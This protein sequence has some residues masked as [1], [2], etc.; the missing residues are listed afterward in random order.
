MTKISKQFIAAIIT[1]AILLAGCA[2]TTPTL[3]PSAP[4]ATSAVPDSPTPIAKT[5]SSSSVETTRPPASVSPTDASDG[6]QDLTITILYDN[7]AYDARLRAD[8]GFA[9]LIEY[10]GHTL[11]FD[12]GGDGPTL[13]DNMAQLGIAPRSIEAIVLSHIHGDHTNGLQSVLDTDITPTVYVPAS[14][15]ASF[16]DNVRSQTDL[17]EIT[18]PVEIFP[19]LHSTGELGASIVEQALVV[20]TE[21]GIVVVTGCAHPGIV[22]IV[23]QA[24]AIVENRVALVVGGFHLLDYSSD[25]VTHIV[26][27]LRELGVRQVCPTHCTGDA[28][29]AIFAAQY[30]DDY[31]QGGVGRVITVAGSDEAHVSGLADDEIATLTSL[32]RVDDYPLYTMHYYGDYSHR[33][34]A[35]GGGR[36]RLTFSTPDW[37]CSLFAAL[38]D[39]DNMLY[40]RNFDWEYSPALLLFT[41]PTDGYASVS[42]VDI[43][44]LVGADV[45]GRLTD[46]PFEER[47]ALLDAP[48]WP[49]DGMNEHGLVIGMAAV[50]PG[51]VSPD[52]N[53]ETIGSL[54]IIREVL[55]HASDTDEAVAILQSYNIDM[56]GGPP[57]HYLVA[58]PAGRSVLVEFYQGETVLIPNP[59][60]EPWHQATNFL[61]SSVGESATGEC[62]RYDRISE[63]LVE[64][65]GR[66]TVSG[67][68]DLLAEVSQEGTQWS[69]VYGLST[70][71]VTV[72]MGQK[73][74]NPH[75][76]YLGLAGE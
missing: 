57:L 36:A 50:P 14:F 48:L 20:E 67:A 4:P 40:G 17:V 66:L 64:V 73:Y 55:D 33:R 74:D 10:G 23:Q 2:G 53:K 47:R 54:G 72:T 62:W 5:P 30:G 46:L 68:M 11:L 28:A 59:D 8:W 71:D 29:I 34:A 13:M 58:D 3:S 6:F 44:Y 25:Q 70:G 27:E 9:A 18:D 39:A 63:R 21:A 76:F 51:H 65:E 26:A 16:K 49:F 42:M 35:I 38:G 22:P 24:K 37:A 75:T 45:A 69:I 52:P 60:N 19:G 41:D 12:T 1:I 56:G 43:E 61:R 7:T 32:E 31:V 15:P